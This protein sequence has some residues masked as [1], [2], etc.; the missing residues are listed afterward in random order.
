MPQSLAQIYLH[1]VFSTKHRQPFLLDPAIRTEAHNYLGGCCNGLKCQVLIVGGVED[2]V[3]I[4]CCLARTI[5]VADLVRDAKRE[6]SKWLKNKSDD[7]AAFDWQNGYGA[8]SVGPGELDVVRHYVAGQEEHH[9]QETFQA[10]YLRMLARAGVAYDE[11]YL[12]D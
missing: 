10:E 1:L 4:L 12:W 11:K 8:F 2:H 6:S 9:R 7:L 3:H 5:T